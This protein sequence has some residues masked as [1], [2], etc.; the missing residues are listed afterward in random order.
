[1]SEILLEKY[2]ASQFKFGFEL[3]AF[4]NDGWSDYGSTDY[5][6]EDEENIRDY[7]NELISNEFGLP[8]KEIEIKGDGSLNPSD[9]EDYP[10]EWATPTMT[11]N[12]QNLKKCITGLNR[13][14]NY[15]GIYTNETCG[16]HVHLSFPDMSDTDIIW[17]ISQ[18]AIDDEMFD[19]LITFKGID[20]MDEDY[21]DS[22]FMDEIKES[23]LSNNFKWL[24][25]YFTTEKYRA[26]HIHQQ[27]TLEWRGPRNF[28]NKRELQTIKDF[29]KLLHE[30]VLWIS[31]ATVAKSINGI[32]KE[33]YFKLVFGE[34]YN[35]GDTIIKDFSTKRSKE[36]K[37]KITS[38]V[39]N[40][41][42]MTLVNL[43]Q[44]YNK[45]RTPEFKKLIDTFLDLLTSYTFYNS[46][47]FLAKT[48]EELYR[49]KDE[50]CLGI[51]LGKIGQH[52]QMRDILLECEYNTY[53]YLFKM[54]YSVIPE[55]MVILLKNSMAVYYN[56]KQEYYQKMV[57]FLS[58][59]KNLLGMDDWKFIFSDYK[60][61]CKYSQ[62]IDNAEMIDEDLLRQNISNLLETSAN[63]E[64]YLDNR[65]LVQSQDFKWIMTN[66][67]I[68]VAKN[69]VVLFSVIE[70]VLKDIIN[71]LRDN[72]L[73]NNM[74]NEANLLLQRLYN[75]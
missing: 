55:Q 39:K 19:K 44:K 24:S 51:I 37:E 40:D 9:D 69:H 64:R 23:I 21:A 2:L 16:F 50:D 61:L 48:I 49:Q 25:S 22:N 13:L 8:Y 52:H 45:N 3:E 58:N 10:F 41:K 62:L 11:F 59:N 31:K 46:D 35:M 4:L 57:K 73:E 20:F 42:Y 67:V 74:K 36:A 26:F 28:L 12:P 6:G 30:F 17:I 54:M 75:N 7:L 29:F 72:K 70:S 14:I 38:I 1:M 53:E 34:K 18:L 60:I 43:L 5:D 56:S 68:G 15:R 27:G 71:R 32:N 63:S 47:T 65:E 33:T 66:N